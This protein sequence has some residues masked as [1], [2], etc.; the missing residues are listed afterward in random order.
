M[1]DLRQTYTLCNELRV[2]ISCKVSLC[3]Q[4]SC[5]S[6]PDSGCHTCT[7]LGSSA[8]TSA[9]SLAVYPKGWR[10]CASCWQ[11]PPHTHTDLY[12]GQWWACLISS[13]RHQGSGF[14]TED[15]TSLT[16]TETRKGKCHKASVSK[17][18]SQEYSWC[19][20]AGKG[21]VPLTQ[22]RLSDISCVPVCVIH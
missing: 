1:K 4:Q 5:L 21:S 15:L 12:H 19:N 14:W 16:V 2:G 9:P 10:L 11:T 8:K 13:M 20:T 6:P 7:R 17:L 3:A 22:I 18:I